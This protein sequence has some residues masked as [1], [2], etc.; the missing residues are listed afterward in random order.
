M[1]TNQYLPGIG[2][3]VFRSESSWVHQGKRLCQNSV[4]RWRLLF[5][6]NPVYV[7]GEFV[8][9]Q[10]EDMRLIIHTLGKFLSHR[11]VKVSSLSSLFVLVVF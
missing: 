6:D 5:L 7:K 3:Q 10:V 1:S 4:E 9:F 11:D 8:S 2:V